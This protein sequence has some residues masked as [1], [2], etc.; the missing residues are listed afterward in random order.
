VKF[1]A[2][3]HLHSRFS[4]A[5]S[6]EMTFDTMAAWAKVK[7]IN[8]LASADF[9]H[10]EWFFLTKEKLE[11]AGNGFFRLRAPQKP[12]NGHLKSVPFSRDDVAFV[13]STELSFI[14]SK[15]GKVRK[16]HL[17]LLAPDFES[18]EK[19]NG[20]LHGLG[21]NLTS[22]GRPILG[23]DARMFV[24][25]VADICPRCVVIPSHIWT[26][27]FSVFGANSG[28]DSL[29]ECFEEMTPFLFALE[30]GLSSD[31][32]MNWRLSA[33]DKYALVS[34]SDA[35]SPSKI[36]REANAVEAEFGYKGLIEAIRSKDPARFLYTV[37]FF[38][39]EGKYHYDGHRKCG[40]ML[41]PRESLAHNDLCPA[42]GK[43]L[44]IGVAHRVE[45]L[46][47]R[48]DIR[49]A[50]LRV[51]FK[52]LIPLNEIIAEACGKTAECQSVWDTYFR[53]I[54]EFG[55]E[56]RILT[57]VSIGDLCALGPEK[58]GRG[59]ERMRKGL[60]KIEPGH[61]GEYGIIRLF[62]QDEDRA[63]AGAGQMSLF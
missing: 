41:S 56:H 28:F 29:E 4:R 61:D 5:T 20:R 44:T 14:Y 42:C 3:L 40:V 62:E 2:D 59:V 24:K 8:V 52:S 37:E 53:F 36:G 63:A 17:L 7:G 25:L 26:P 51:P 57:E 19:I 39:E 45:E 22:D 33:L 54:H 58:V 11:P 35:H 9:T 27:W 60:V 21:A 34:N 32:P 48:N 47:D 43:K 6:R 38:P 15:Q 49:D 55:D 10:P 31:P 30:T 23:L 13:L 46:A 18:V 16:V 50:G 12:E 1:L